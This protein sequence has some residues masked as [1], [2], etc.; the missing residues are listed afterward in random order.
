MA[1]N[2]SFHLKGAV[3]GGCNCD[4]GCPC[5]FEVP[6]SKGFCE[7]EYVWC[8]E[9][10]H[11]NGVQLDGLNFGMFFHSPAAIHLGNLTTVAIGDVR[12]TKEQRTA[13]EAMIKGPPHSACS[14]T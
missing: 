9:H 3:L 1:E 4:W 8:V 7:G 5:N 10:G 6:P 13:L 14:W 11:Y 12:A 2:G